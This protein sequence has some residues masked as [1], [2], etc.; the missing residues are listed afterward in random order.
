MQ[1]SDNT[2]TDLFT[3][4]VWRYCDHRSWTS[5]VSRVDIATMLQL[6]IACKMSSWGPS[7]VIHITSTSATIFNL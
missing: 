5:D 4:D 2:T 3:A 6:A 1:V 7:H